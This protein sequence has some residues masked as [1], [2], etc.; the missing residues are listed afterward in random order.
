MNVLILGVNGF[1]GSQLKQNLPF[2]IFI[3]DKKKS[4]AET[5]S[6]EAIARNIEDNNISVIINCCG[7]YSNDYDVDYLANVQV[8]QNILRVVSRH[9]LNVKVILFGSSAEYGITS[10]DPI[11]EGMSCN[12]KSIYGITKY[13][14]YLLSKYYT[15]NFLLNIVYLRLFNIHGI[16]APE[17]LVTG[18]LLKY[19]RDGEVNLK[20]G[21][22]SAQR[23]YLS[24]EEFVECVR[25]F[26]EVKHTKFLY[27]IGKGK[28]VVVRDMLLDILKNHDIHDFNLIEREG[29]VSD[30]IIYPSIQKFIKLRGEY[31]E[32]SK[33]W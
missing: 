5:Y 10:N 31:Y 20:F 12:P 11:D 30:D 2:N 19:I 33:A 3:L 23:D 25:V 15:H 8:T 13:T 9:Q 6:C 21:P 17:T 16:T 14:Q 7:S 22:L 29:D 4:R 24:T 1:L 27:N 28:P 32:K 26:C 18:K